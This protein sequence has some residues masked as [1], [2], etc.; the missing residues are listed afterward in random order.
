MA[1]KKVQGHARGLNGVW[2]VGRR[3]CQEQGG[4]VMVV[5]VA[6]EG[7]GVSAGIVARTDSGAGCSYRVVQGLRIVSNGRSNFTRRARGEGGSSVT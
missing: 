1:C 3:R 2:T 4:S 7:R 6:G 5:T